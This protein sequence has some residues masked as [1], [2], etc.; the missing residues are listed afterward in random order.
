M[1]VT[2]S[3]TLWDVVARPAAS[4]QVDH[5]ETEVDDHSQRPAVPDDWVS[6]QVD[7]SLVGQTQIPSDHQYKK[8][9]TLLTGDRKNTKP[10]VTD[11]P[12]YFTIPALF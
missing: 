11:C 2:G 1:I 9:G 12:L 8:G 5:Q 7:L 10:T 6:N 3:L 4:H